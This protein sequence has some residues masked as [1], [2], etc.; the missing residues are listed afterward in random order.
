MRRARKPGP[1]T[2]AS[3]DAIAAFCGGRPPVVI[4][5]LRSQKNKR[6]I[7]KARRGCTVT[8]H[9]ISDTENDGFVLA[10]D[11][12]AAMRRALANLFRSVGLRYETLSSAEEL[13]ALTPPDGPTCLVLD[14]RLRGISG[15]EIQARLRQRQ[16]PIPIIFIS[17]YADFAM[18]VAGMKGG[19]CDFIA[20]PFRDQELL[21]AVHRALDVDRKRRAAES[22]VRAL[23]ARFAQ[24]TPREQEVMSLATAGLLNKQVA[25][26]IG[27][28]EATVKIHRGQVMRK[29]QADS[30]AELVTMADALAVRRARA[31]TA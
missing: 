3:R 10:V 31:L 27:I 20:K 4:H 2:T 14:V 21:D 1:P 7:A 17:G 30:F 19:A 25:S 26:A 13:L 23:R 6:G 29:M 16:H 28:T 8:F 22:R 9:A 12:D 15:L 24:L 18:G 11:D 5:F